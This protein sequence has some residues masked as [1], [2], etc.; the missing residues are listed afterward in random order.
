MQPRVG[1]DSASAGYYR[2]NLQNGVEVE[3]SASRHAEYNFPDSN[4]NVLLIDLS[5]QLPSNAQAEPLKSQNI[6]QRT[7]GRE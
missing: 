1:K 2:L 7:I 3:L 4:N 5:H 6:Q